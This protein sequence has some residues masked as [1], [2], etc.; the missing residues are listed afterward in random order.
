LTGHYADDTVFMSPAVLI[1]QP[2]SHGRTSGK[3]AI[4]EC[5][6]RRLERSPKLR[7]EAA[8]VH[9]Y[10]QPIEFITLCYYYNE[11]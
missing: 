5:Y 9:K 2:G 3:A 6:R 11:T 7:F 1:A 10:T 8:L 4:R